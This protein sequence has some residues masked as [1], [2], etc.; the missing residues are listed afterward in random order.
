[1]PWSNQGGGPWGSGPKGPWGSG[2]QSGGGSTPPDLEDLLRRS[3]DKL[4]NLLPG[5]NMGGRGFILLGMAAIAAVACLRLL[6][7]RLARSSARSC[8]SENSCA[9]RRPA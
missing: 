7:G 9:P 1:M 2:P 6:P 8:A 5:G 4:K 3:Q